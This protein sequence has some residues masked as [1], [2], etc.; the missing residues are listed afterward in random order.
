M[1]IYLTVDGEEE[2]RCGI[3]VVHRGILYGVPTLQV[4]VPM[5]TA[6]ITDPKVGKECWN[7]DLDARLECWNSDLDAW[8]EAMAA[9][10]LLD[11]GRPSPQRHGCWTRMRTL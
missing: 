9:S 11:C 4:E 3:D 10:I 6:S 7:S 8:Q 5:A 1:N 2:G